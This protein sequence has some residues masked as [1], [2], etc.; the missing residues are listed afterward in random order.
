MPEASVHEYR[1]AGLGEDDVR[2]A[3]QAGNMQAEPQAL[4]MKE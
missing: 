2:S 3:G 4:T 1:G